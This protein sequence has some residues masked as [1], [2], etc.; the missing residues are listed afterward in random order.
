M[1]DGRAVDSRFF[2]NFFNFYKMPKEKKKRSQIE[3]FPSCADISCILDLIYG[4]K[5]LLL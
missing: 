2:F 1:N 3:S 5:G 4:G